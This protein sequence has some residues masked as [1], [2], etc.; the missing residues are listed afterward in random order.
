[1]LQVALSSASVVASEQDSAAAMSFQR[2]SKGVSWVE[3]LRTVQEC[4]RK[5]EA[6]IRRGNRRAPEILVSNLCGNSLVNPRN[7]GTCPPGAEFERGNCLESERPVAPKKAVL[8]I[9]PFTKTDL[10][11]LN[12]GIQLHA[13]SANDRCC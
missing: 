13:M 6:R 3:A 7:P 11:R 1:V 4:D 5:M 2:G 10:A 8:S 9:A 12:R